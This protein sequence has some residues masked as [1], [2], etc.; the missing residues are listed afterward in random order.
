M[1]MVVARTGTGGSV[2]CPKALICRVSTV[3]VQRFC[4]P[5]SF[6]QDPPKPYE[7]RRENGNFGNAVEF[8]AVAQPGT[9]GARP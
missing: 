2:F 7:I 5:P 3:A 9:A 6:A 1:V 8:R 4:K